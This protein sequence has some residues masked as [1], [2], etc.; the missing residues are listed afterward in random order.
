MT[1]HAI[2]YAYKPNCR[3]CGKVGSK[4]CDT[5]YSDKPYNGN[6]ILVKERKHEWADGRVSYS[7]TVWDGVTYKLNGGKFCTS[8]CAIAWANRNAVQPREAE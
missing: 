5:I 2:L 6:Q 7:S 1:H 8:S 4:E 3:Q